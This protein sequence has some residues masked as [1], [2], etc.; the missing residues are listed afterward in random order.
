MN[1]TTGVAKEGVGCAPEVP[2]DKSDISGITFAQI[3]PEIPEAVAS[4]IAAQPL[5]GTI[6]APVRGEDEVKSS[7]LSSAG[8]PI[9]S[10]LSGNL[11]IYDWLAWVRYREARLCL[12]T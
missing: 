3:P 9:L 4:K 7:E 10:G 2:E 11:D 5:A 6:E 8:S 1:V 12:G